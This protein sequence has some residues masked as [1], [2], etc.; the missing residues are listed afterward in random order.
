[1]RELLQLPDTHRIGIVPG[2]DTGAFE[3]AMWTMLGA[4]GVTTLAWESFG[5]GWVTDAV[6]QLKL[7]PTILR[8]DYGQIPD[9]SQID[10][11]DDVL[12]AAVRDP[13][14]PV[15]HAHGLTLE[16]VGYPADE[17]L[18]ARLVQTMARRSPEEVAE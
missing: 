5:E 10:W 7:D 14:V 15:V 3:M 16:E 8:A 18:E 4:R 2:S 11:A 6:K 1:M 12:R 17:D 9:L 13:A